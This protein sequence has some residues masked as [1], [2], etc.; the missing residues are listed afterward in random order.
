MSEIHEA[1]ENNDVDRVKS[2]LSQDPTTRDLD[3]GSGNRPIHV[4][5]YSGR[6]AIL[7]LL[8]EHGADV[9][10]CG[11][12]NR[13]PLHFAAI[14]GKLAIAKLLINNGSHILVLDAHGNTPLYYTAQ[15]QYETTALAKL[16]L[17]QSVTPDA[18]SAIWLMNSKDLKI[19]SQLSPN[20]LHVGQPERLLTDAVIKGDIDLVKFLLEQGIPVDGSESYRPL[21]LA[22]SRAD[23]IK[24]LLKHG[25]DLSARDSFGDTCLNRAIQYNLPKSVLKLLQP[26]S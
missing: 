4:A 24:V 19:Q 8:L 1:I 11:D 12:M 15:G 22:L 7:E 13:I 3:D 16:L 20:Y 10:S 2:M 9:N 26:H 17:K 6:T 25:A 18:N 23:I 21:L 5:V 14:E